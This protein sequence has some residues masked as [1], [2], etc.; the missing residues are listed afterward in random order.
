M[1]KSTQAS[2]FSTELMWQVVAKLDEQRQ[3]PRVPVKIRA[4]IRSDDGKK[5]AADVIDI[6]PDGLQLRCS[7]ETA[8]YLHATAR[9][10]GDTP[11]IRL[12]LG[13]KIEIGGS[14]RTLVMRCRVLY[15]TTV[16]SEPKC[17]MG[18]AFN[19]LDAHSERW[20]NIFFAE[21]LVHSAADEAVA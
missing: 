21:Q 13:I 6:S 20:L 2:A 18:L 4:A 8:R 7:T 11:D 12:N 9:G 16:D 19:K 1:P 5:L 10:N 14:I 17:V 15:L 3:H